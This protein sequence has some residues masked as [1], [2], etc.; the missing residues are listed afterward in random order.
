MT[1]LDIRKQ[2]QRRVRKDRKPESRCLRSRRPL[3]ST[4]QTITKNHG[5]A[6][7][8]LKRVIQRHGGDA[9]DVGFAPVGEN[10][11]RHELL[12]EPFVGVTN[13]YGQLAATLCRITR[14]DHRYAVVADLIE[15]PFKIT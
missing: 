13:A 11:I 14:S 8:V 4:N 5:K 15:Q 2:H 3:R 9:D 12:I 1:T 7:Y 6:F 10:I